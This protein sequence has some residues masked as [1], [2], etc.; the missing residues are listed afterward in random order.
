M[1][2][3]NK[4]TIER[5]L[6]TNLEKANAIGSAAT[7]AQAQELL[8]REAGH[9]E[10]L[11]KLRR[12]NEFTCLETYMALLPVWEDCSR[13]MSQGKKQEYVQQKYGAPDFN[14]ILC[15]QWSSAQYKKRHREIMACRV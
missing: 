12:D 3:E 10:E 15:Q 4:S 14:Q 13:K 5:Q 8:I 11:D 7:P 9:I 2:Q 6:R 1:P